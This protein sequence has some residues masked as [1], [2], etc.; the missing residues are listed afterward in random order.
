MGALRGRVPRGLGKRREWG[1]F[2]ARRFPE[3]K[4]RDGW[5]RQI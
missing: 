4:G 2:L 3:K 1:Q 5:R